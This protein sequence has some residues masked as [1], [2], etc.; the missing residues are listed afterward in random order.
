MRCVLS[1]R[2]TEARE[3]T[4]ASSVYHLITE[5]T[6]LGKALVI[7]EPSAN[8]LPL[9]EAQMWLEEPSR[10][11]CLGTEGGLDPRQEIALLALY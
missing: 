11:T 8:L 10:K 5:S 7:L 9:L 3:K 4:R 6:G 1:P 2:I